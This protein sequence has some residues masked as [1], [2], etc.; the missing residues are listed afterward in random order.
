MFPHPVTKLHKNVYHDKK[1]L[2]SS[3]FLSM[4]TSGISSK[5]LPNATLFFILMN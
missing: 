5:V 3:V 2:S 1:K 4:T